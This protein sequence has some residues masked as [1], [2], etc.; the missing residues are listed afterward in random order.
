MGAS[1]DLVVVAAGSSV[2]MGGTDKVLLEVAGRPALQHSLD[3]AASSPA[4]RRIVVVAAEPRIAE[5]AALPWLPDALVAIAAG[6]A[7]RAASVAA[8]LEALARAPGPPADAVLIHDAARPGLAPEMLEA[9]A[10]AA[11]RTG[12]AV[13]VL[14]IVDTL[15]R[16]AGE[17]GAELS[18]GTVDRSQ[19]RAAQTPQGVAARHLDAFVARLLEEG[20]DA[21]DDASVLE[22]LGV[23]VALVPGSERLRKITTPADTVA[24]EALLAPASPAAS[25]LA[26]VLRGVD[27]PGSLRIGWGEDAHPI[28]EAGTL[29]LGGRAFQGHSALAGH[30]DGDVVLHAVADALI[31]AA[32]LGDLGRLFPADERTPTGI[33]SGALLDESRARAA[34]V[35]VA[36]LSVDLIIHARAPRLAPYLDEIAANVARHLGIGADAVS[37]KASTGN[38]VG[39]E[40]GGRA[41]RCTALL[42]ARADTAK[43]E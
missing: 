42:L 34:A 7:T 37:A 5:L 17:P 32:R 35:G 20:A 4:V 36:P 27:G 12:A 38:L 14:P 26:A 29:V 2:R 15:K 41:I 6:G 31:G 9:V 3:A 10:E 33:A 40:G 13:P 28:S 22:S 23:P 8:G 25:H 39:D 16:V 1:I 21:T 43:G 24:L 30:S 19:L 11:H 18:D